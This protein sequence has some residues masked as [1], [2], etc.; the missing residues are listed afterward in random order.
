V[1]Q[2]STHK[3]PPRRRRRL[4]AR[5]RRPFVA[6][7]VLLLALATSAAR[8]ADRP[9]LPDM[10]FKET[11][12]HYRVQSDVS[13][14]FTKTVA[15]HMESLF[16][17]YSRRLKGYN[18]IKGRFEIRVFRAKSAYDRA[19]PMVKGSAGVFISNMQLLA[20]HAERNT[21]EDVL[22]TLYHEGFHQFMY[23]A[24]SPNCPVWLNEGLAEYFGAAT[25]NGKKFVTGECPTRRIVM[26]RAIMDDRKAI[27]F[28]DLFSM[29]DADWLASVR[30][31]PARATVQYVQAWAIVHFLVHADEGRYAKRLEEVVRAIHKSKPGATAFLDVFGK[32]LP[33]FERLWTRYAKA[34]EPTPKYAARD[35]MGGILSLAAFIYTDPGRLTGLSTLRKESVAGRSWT[36]TTPAGVPIPSHDKDAVDRLFRCPL[37]RRGGFLLAVDPQSK[38]PMLVCTH[39]PGVIL[40]ARY[41]SD[42]RGGHTV[43]AEEIARGTV[44]RAIQA[45]ILS[46]MNK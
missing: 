13:E 34:M 42:G 12:T 33:K 27:P 5:A 8:S 22:R 41:H 19:L 30:K 25:W 21:T 29:T 40:L 4:K 31:D 17:D 14:E 24:V 43:R 39:H 35:R 23:H 38:L 6:W 45:A 2:H 28:K 9:R 10:P 36:M 7:A 37:A 20:A 26:L 44:P 32:D 46:A 18:K 1:T 3:L 11:T 15:R 16:Q